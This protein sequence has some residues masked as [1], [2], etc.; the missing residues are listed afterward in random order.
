[1]KLEF[2]IVCTIVEAG[3]GL[4]VGS[5]ENAA[6]EYNPKELYVLVDSTVTV[7][8]LFVFKIVDSLVKITVIPSA[9]AVEVHICNSPLAGSIPKVYVPAGRIEEPSRWR[10]ECR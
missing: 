8:N 3:F 4:R 1:M 9:V 7:P 6:I 2:G 5:Q 10:N